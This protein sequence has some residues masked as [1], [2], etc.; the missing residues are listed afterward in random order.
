MATVSNS[1]VQKNIT[2]E[3]SSILLE[4]VQVSKKFV[5]KYHIYLGYF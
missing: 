2:E 3:I 4:L 1:Y 5:Y